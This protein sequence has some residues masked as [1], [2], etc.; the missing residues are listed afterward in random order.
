MREQAPL[1]LRVRAW[2]NRWRRRWWQARFYRMV[3]GERNASPGVAPWLPATRISPSTCIEH[4]AGLVLADDV[5][6]GHFN[7]IDASGGV[8]IDTGAQITNFV[9]ILSH[10][11]H[12]SVRVAKA[13]SGLAPAETQTGALAGDVRAPVRIGAH[14]FVGPHTTIEAGSDIGALCL[15]ASHSLVRGH[16]PPGSVI[17][18]RPARVVGDVRDRDRSWL[19]DQPASWRA[20]YEAWLAGIDGPVALHEADASARSHL[21]DETQALADAAGPTASADRTAG[22]GS[23]PADAAVAEGASPGTPASHGAQAGADAEAGRQGAPRHAGD[24]RA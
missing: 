4:E 20:A 8:Q 23:S 14:V 3:F 16:F 17:A 15:I 12:R 5:F 22:A 6:I 11:T 21:A 7:F 13:L 18:G 2:I 19:A 9:S 24:Q 10:S 1:S